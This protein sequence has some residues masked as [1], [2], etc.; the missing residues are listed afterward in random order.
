MRWSSEDPRAVLAGR[1][2]GG[3]LTGELCEVE[4]IDG[5]L[6]GCRHLLGQAS[7]PLPDGALV[8]LRGA[9]WYLAA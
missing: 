5:P 3:A 6:R 2:V 7:E 8:V 4:L 1:I 9:F